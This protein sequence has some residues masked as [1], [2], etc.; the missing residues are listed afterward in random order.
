[1][2]SRDI[3]N[4]CMLWYGLRFVVYYYYMGVYI[5]NNHSQQDMTSLSYSVKVSMYSATCISDPCAAVN[6]YGYYYIAPKH[7]SFLILANPK[8]VLIRQVDF[9]LQI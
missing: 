8:M 1:M 6:L 9:K 2:G 5:S 7:Q 3:I 4:Y